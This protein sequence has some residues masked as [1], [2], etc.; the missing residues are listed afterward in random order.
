[1]SE[2]RVV[3][4]ARGRR[5]RVSGVRAWPRVARKKANDGGSKA[6]KRS[7][8]C[9]PIYP[10]RYRTV[11]SVSCDAQQ[12]GR[13]AYGVDHVPSKP[14]AAAR[15][16][17]PA[18]AVAAVPW[19][20]QHAH[21]AADSTA[22]AR[23][24]PLPASAPTTARRRLL[25]APVF[26]ARARAGRAV[27]DERGRPDPARARN[28][29]NRAAHGAP[30]PRSPAR[31]AR[32]ARAAAAAA[33]AGAGGGARGRLP[34]A[35]D[36]RR[37]AAPHAAE[38][39]VVRH[40]GRPGRLPV[41]GRRA[42]PAR[43]ARR[44]RRA[45]DVLPPRAL[46]GAHVARAA[47]VPAAGG[48]GRRARRGAAGAGARARAVPA[49]HVPARQR[50]L[51][52]RAP[53]RAVARARRPGGGVALAA[54][55]AAPA[56]AH[57][58]N[59]SKPYQ[60][61]AIKTH[62]LAARSRQSHCAANAASQRAV[63]VPFSFFFTGQ[64]RARAAQLQLAGGGDLDG[65]GR[66]AR[67]AANLLDGPHHVQAADHRAEHHV[68]AVQPRGLLRADE[69]L[70]AVGVGPG[71]GHGQRAGAQ[72]LER[73]VLVVELVAVDGLAARAVVV[74]EVTALAH[75]VGDHAVDCGARQGG[76]GGW[77][78][79][80]GRAGVAK[81]LLA[82]AERAKVLGG[83]RHHV[84][85]QL[86][87]DAAGRRAADLHVEVHPRVGSHGAGRSGK[88][89]RVCAAGGAGEGGGGGAG[90]E[91]VRGDSGARGRE[92]DGRGGALSTRCARSDRIC[93]R[94][95]PRKGLERSTVILL[96]IGWQGFPCARARAWT[97][98]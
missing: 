3:S 16:A 5:T 76:G 73:E 49:E 98:G 38:R 29:T 28:T 77:R 22:R 90:A 69:E 83:L 48:G 42:L 36:P 47:V 40:G 67:A 82:G 19:R 4:R 39:A 32:A 74:G 89:G 44:G 45:H 2:S 52:Q 66:G 95:Q 85:A 62:P 86:H 6:T 17:P 30:A 26:S 79:G 43:G 84:G 65:L 57:L 53:A 15:N 64:S 31:A 23:R 92:A 12:T 33:G 8:R 63:L 25:N 24:Q 88:A 75:E 55:A 60:D 96:F 14:P 7:V 20:Q 9:E 11:P 21:T 94:R 80:G 51:R 87:D 1:M 41:R 58:Y 35:A 68:L 81:A 59:N 78:L 54:A 97:R 70:R 56:L 50:L 34:V 37:H 93:A 18:A 61:T 71:V 72:V 27:D 13:Y 91:R 10:R 46:R